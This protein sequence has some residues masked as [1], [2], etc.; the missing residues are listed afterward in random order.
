MTPGVRQVP[1]NRWPTLIPIGFAPAP[2]KTLGAHRS[3][4]FSLPAES[5][6][7]SIQVLSKL[8]ASANGMTV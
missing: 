1:N 7:P 4:L 2:P 3:D 8:P 6:S 5:H